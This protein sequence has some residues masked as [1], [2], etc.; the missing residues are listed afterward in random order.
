MH[1]LSLTMPAV[2]RFDDRLVK[3]IRQIIYVSICAENNVAAPAAIAAVRSALRHKLLT[4]KTDTAPPA[5]AR[6][7]KNFDSIDKHEAPN[8]TL[9][10]RSAT[11]E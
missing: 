1:F 10:R 3:K 11:V 2:F 5:I 8:Y 4:P 6:L 9:W 7:R